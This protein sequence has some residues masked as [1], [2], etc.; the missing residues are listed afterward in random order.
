[1]QDVVNAGTSDWLTVCR[2]VGSHGGSR[3]QHDK[4]TQSS[5]VR[6]LLNA[7]RFF[8]PCKCPHSVECLHPQSNALLE[9][10]VV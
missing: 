10:S 5:T 6:Y 4:S 3:T 2:E 1:M 7:S 9:R 8:S